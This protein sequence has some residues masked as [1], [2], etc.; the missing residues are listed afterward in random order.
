MQIVSITQKILAY[1]SFLSFKEYAGIERAMGTAM[2]SDA[3]FDTNRKTKFYSNF[4]KQK[5]S[6]ELFEK[7]LSKDILPIYEQRFQHVSFNKV[8]SDR[9]LLLNQKLNETLDLDAYVW[10]TNT[11]N[12]INQLKIVDDYLATK[13]SLNIKEELDLAYFYFYLFSF[14]NILSIVLF[15]ALVI[16]IY[17]M[18]NNEEKLKKIMNEHIISSTT[19]LKGVITSVSEA[20]C[21][22]SGY[23]R[24]ELIGEPH[25]IIRHPDVPK[26]AFKNLWN[27]IQNNKVWYGE[28]KNLKKDGGFYWVEA[29]VSPIYND[30]NIKVGYSSIRHNITDNKKVEELNSTLESKIAKAIEDITKKDKQIMQQSRLAQMGEMISMIA[31]QWRQPLAAI[32]ST[33]SAIGLKSQLNKLDNKTAIELSSK[34]SSYTQHLSATINDFRDFFQPNK[35]KRETTYAKLIN[36]VLNII[37]V[38]IANKNIE[39]IMELESQETLKTYPNEIKQVILNLIKN[40]EDVLL[41]REV[42]NPFI[43]VKTYSNILIVSDNGGGIQ[44]DILD[45]IFDPYFSTKHEHDGTGLGLYMSKVI[46]ENHC[47]GKLYVENSKNNEGAIFTIELPLKVETK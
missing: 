31:H 44:E 14:L 4:E 2:I 11:T 9:I 1:S 30:N 16:S 6:K 32:S 12:K 21:N 22:I 38:S 3:I 26:Q 24:N 8:T 17:K 47:D 34:I 18:L 41:E 27:T 25:N 20:F 35:E 28:V 5:Y 42:V 23:T 19:D 40:A 13:I 36:T 15:I 7:Y 45:K 39:L 46:I 29:I 37:E 33:S 43:K 10:F